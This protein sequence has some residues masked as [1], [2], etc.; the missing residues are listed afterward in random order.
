V[1]LP[2]RFAGKCILA[3][4]SLTASSC[5]ATTV[6]AVPTVTPDGVRFVLVNHGARS[7]ALAGSFNLWSASSHPLV[8]DETRGLWSIVVPLPPGEHVFMY[9]VDG[10]RWITP[11]L[12]EDYVDDGFG[13][14]NGVVVVRQTGR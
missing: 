6:A 4:L 8:L 1:R 5:S 3:A 10:V 13:S 12:A 7:V 2:A 11:P 14:T 9:V